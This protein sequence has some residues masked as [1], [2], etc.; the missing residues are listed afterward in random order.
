[1]V[2][3]GEDRSERLDVIPAQFRVIVTVRPRY[4]CK[5]CAKG[6]V[7]AL[8]PAHLVEGGLPTEGLLAHILVSKFCDHTPLYRRAGIYARSGVD[9][10]RTSLANGPALGRST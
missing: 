10:D 3:I 9:L 5:T 2:K 6:V 7:Q 1:M 8:A 4:A